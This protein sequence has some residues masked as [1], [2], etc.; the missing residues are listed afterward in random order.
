MLA[1]TNIEPHGYK[2]LLTHG[3][4]VSYMNASRLIAVTF[5]HILPVFLTSVQHTIYHFDL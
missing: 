4:T 3:Y 2:D 1:L 5:Q